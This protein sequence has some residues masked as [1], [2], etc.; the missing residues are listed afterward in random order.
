MTEEENQPGEEMV[1]VSFHCKV[2]EENHV[3]EI[4]KHVSENQPK[5]PF[6]YSYLHGELRD[7]LA[8]LYIDANLKVRGTEVKRIDSD[9]LFA[10]DQVL[11][12]TKTLMAE[13]ADLQ[14]Q[15]AEL[16]EKYQALQAKCGE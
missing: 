15:L 10:K 12:I 9:N 14:E 13:I 11:A 6:T 16:N 4:P 1:K 2:C 7:I 8:I 5:Y 3:V